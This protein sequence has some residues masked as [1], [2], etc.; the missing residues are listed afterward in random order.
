MK[1]LKARHRL[2]LTGTPIQ[3]RVNDLWSLF[4]FLM[5]GFLAPSETAFNSRFGR[6]ILL[7]RDPKATPQLQRAGEFNHFDCRRF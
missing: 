4:D 2:I 6:P 1:K 3:N 5:P 7:T